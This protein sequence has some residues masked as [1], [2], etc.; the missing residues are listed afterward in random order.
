MVQF[1]RRDDELAASVAQYLAGAVL[2][3]GGA[4]LVATPPHSQA[5]TAAM[6]RAGADL[7]AARHEGRFLALDAESLLG[8]FVTGGRVDRD[9]FMASAGILIG[10][11]SAGRWRS[12]GRWSPC[13]GP[14]GT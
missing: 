11:A 7:P 12:T 6:E 5:I 14:P 4:V 2:A 10:Q 8:R 1:Y 3:G 9:A 13:C